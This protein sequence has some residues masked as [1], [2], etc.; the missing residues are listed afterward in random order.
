LGARPL[1]TAYAVRKSKREYFSEHGNRGIRR[2][3][4]DLFKGEEIASASSRK[5]LHGSNLYNN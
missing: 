2:E 4:I 5:I 3:L 1:R